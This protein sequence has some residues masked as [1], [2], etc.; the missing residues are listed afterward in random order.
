MFTRLVWA[1]LAL[2]LAFVAQIVWRSFVPPRCS[3]EC[4][5]PLFDAAELASSDLYFF[6]TDQPRF[7]WQRS[8]G[9]P[10]EQLARFAAALAGLP[11]LSRSPPLAC[12][13][14]RSFAPS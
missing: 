12:L 13:L 9:S 10:P 4:L 6:V 2:Y 5:R 8:D 11:L 3:S 14:V 1:A 7:A